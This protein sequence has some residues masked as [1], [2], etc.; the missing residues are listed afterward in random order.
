MGL[1]LKM[2][3]KFKIFYYFNKKPRF[4]C[5][6]DTLRRYVKKCEEPDVVHLK[7]SKTKERNILS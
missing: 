5:T 2:K 6:P 1:Y 4:L 3:I 7:I